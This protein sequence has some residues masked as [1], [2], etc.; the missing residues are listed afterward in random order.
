VLGVAEDV[1]CELLD[2]R[3]DPSGATAE[4][5]LGSLPVGSWLAAVRAMGEIAEGTAARVS[6]TR[7]GEHGFSYH[8]LAAVAEAQ[9]RAAGLELVAGP[10]ALELRVAVKGEQAEVRGRLASHPLSRRGYLVRR[11]DGMTEPTVARA[12]VR[13][14]RPEK[15]EKWLDPFC[16]CG[17][18]PAE[19]GLEEGT[20]HL[21]A[22]DVRPGRLKDAELNLAR[23]G[24]GCELLELD[25][26]ALPFE[27]RSFRAVVTHPPQSDPETGRRWAPAR[28]KALLDEL[29]RVLE[30]GGRLVVFGL[31]PKLVSGAAKDEPTWH[32]RGR[33]RVGLRGRN[34]YI[35]VIEKEL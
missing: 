14:A 4:G 28:L 25:A 29:V 24:V 22:G 23:A 5:V 16:G 11:R 20:S 13:L 35:F 21:V 26:F 8:E 3:F 1:F 9:L 10:S 19:R 18:I 6:V 30:Y 34:R 33:T 12:M 31:E 32:I 2:R 7:T 17:V 15:H 27:E